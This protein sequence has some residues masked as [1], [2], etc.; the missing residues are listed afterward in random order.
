LLTCSI[1]VLA[2][3]HNPAPV[4]VSVSPAI[5][6]PLATFSDVVTAASCAF[7]P[8]PNTFCH[9]VPSASFTIPGEEDNGI[10]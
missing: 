7:F 2:F 1:L 4:L 8:N 9:S 5:E 6:A 10:N 3:V